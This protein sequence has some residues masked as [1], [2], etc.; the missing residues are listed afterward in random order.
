MVRTAASD[1]MALNRALDNVGSYS[2]EKCCRDHNIK[3]LAFGPAP[4]CCNYFD[5]LFS[6]NDFVLN[7]HSRTDAFDVSRCHERDFMTYMVNQS[8]TGCVNDVHL[9]YAFFYY[10]VF[11]YRVSCVNYFY[12]DCNDLFCGKTAF[13]NWK[14]RS[15]HCLDFCFTYQHRRF[16]R[17]TTGIPFALK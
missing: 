3:A 16:L 11:E 4:R 1:C 2:Y 7:M 5:F 17:F 6:V 15:F 13:R 8:V 9:E 14:R 10:F 12:V